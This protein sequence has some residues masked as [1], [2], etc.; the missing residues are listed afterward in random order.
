[1]P[2]EFPRS[3]VKDSAKTGVVA[4]KATIKRKKNKR[5]NLRTF[6]IECHNRGKLFLLA[7]P[8]QAMIF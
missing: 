8:F 4:P 2:E 6:A 5:K 1:M 3:R 7:V